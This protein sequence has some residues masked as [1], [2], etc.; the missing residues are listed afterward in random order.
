MLKI[1]I[2]PRE[3]YQRTEELGLENSANMLA[4]IIEN[5]KDNIKRREAIK[6]LGL[7]SNNSTKLKNECV[8]CQQFAEN[9]DSKYFILKR[10]KY[11]AITMNFYPYNAGHLMVLPIEHKGEL[12][13]L[14]IKARQE[15]MELVNIAIELLKKTM[16]PEGF[17]VGLNL[18]IG[19][20][21]GI[22]SH[23]H[24][25]VLP[26]WVGD[27]NFLATIGETKIVCSDFSHV[28]KQL[29]KELK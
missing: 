7:I 24:F 25:H 3:I 6:Y 23:L 22:P 9:N 2:Q 28:Y 20:G 15:M 19:G 12:L 5:E 26:R 10:F 27:T 17:N 1:K 8:F 4:E 21:G 13:E 29:K 16:K 11:N 14:S 18:G